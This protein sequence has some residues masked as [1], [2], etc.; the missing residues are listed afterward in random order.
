MNYTWA[1]ATD[2]GHVRDHNEDSLAPTEDGS[3]PGPLVVAVADGMG[4]H[5][6]GE[7]ASG[8]AIDAAVSDAAAGLEATTRVTLGN[9][10]VVDATRADD[11]LAGMGTTLT[12]AILGTDGAMHVA[13]VG[14]SRLYLLRDDELRLLTNDHTW[15]GELMA[16]GQLTP[17][18][19]AHHP[20]RHYLT[21]VLGMEEP[22][23]DEITLDLVKR[24]RILVCSDGLTTM[25]EDARIAAHLRHEET[26][27]GAAWALVE[28]ANA[29]GGYDNT[30]VVVIDVG[31]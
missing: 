9:Q 22:T 14:D 7:V 31:P 13:H 23:I 18:Q 15:V 16:R 29:A 6:A 27:T 3:G 5:V 12:L 28:A 21:Q 26:V 20:R 25:L 8:L 30:S 17:D 11:E 4:G 2:S 1:S 24:D 19:A 10:A